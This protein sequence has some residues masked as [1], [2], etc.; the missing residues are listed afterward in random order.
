MTVHVRLRPPQ[1]RY[2][3]RVVPWWRARILITVAPVVLPLAGVGALV[4][5]VRGWFLW[6]AV[7]LAVLGVTTAA[8]LR[9]WR[10]GVDRW[11]VTDH[12]VYTRTGYVLTT[13]R[14]APLSR[15]RGAVLVQPLEARWSGGARVDVLA[16]GLG[17][18]D[19]TAVL[20]TTLLPVAPHTVA[21]EDL[22]RVLP[23]LATAH[24]DRLRPHPRAA[25]ARRLGRAAAASLVLVAAS[26]TA[27]LLW[28]LTGGWLMALALATCVGIVA[29]TA[30]AVDSA[31]ALGHRLT[32]RHLITRRGSLH[33]TSAVLQRDGIIGWRIRQSVFQRRS[34]LVTVSATTAV[35]RG[36]QPVVDIGLTEGLV[37]AAR[38]VPGLLERLLLVAPQRAEDRSPGADETT[39]APW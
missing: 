29:V 1:E 30:L 35:G 31:R 18:D 28:W 10:Y 20:P 7:G 22:G 6:L 39:W 14:V 8:L 34:G 26:T 12:A 2:D 11:E 5:P 19:I 4:A 3:A 33:R 23:D 37:L 9:T 25:L 32:P 16:T 38:A 27:Q 21:R 13:W 36:H 15:S 24:L 17:A